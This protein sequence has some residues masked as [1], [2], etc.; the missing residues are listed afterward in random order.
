MNNYS[1]RMR[2]L[3]FLGY[4]GLSALFLP[5]L[6]TPKLVVGIVVDQMRWDFLYRYQDRY[7]AGG[8][9]KLLADGY[10]FEQVLIPYLPTYTACGHASIY[11][12][13]TPAYHGIVGNEWPQEGELRASVWD[14]R[15]GHSPRNLHATTIGDEL[16]WMTNGRARVFAVSMKARASVLPGGHRADGVFWWNK[17]TGTWRT[18]KFYLDTLP[19]WVEKINN[20]RQ[21]D[22]YYRAG[23]Q[24]LYPVDTYKQSTADEQGYENGLVHMEV[25]KFPYHLDSLLLKKDFGAIITTPFANKM[26]ADFAKSLIEE[27]DLGRNKEQVPDMLAISF[28]ATDYIGHSYGPNSLEIEDTYLRLDTVLADFLRFLENRLGRENVLVFLTADHGVSPVP[29]LQRS[30][31]F[32]ARAM[33]NARQRRTL[34]TFLIKSFPRLKGRSPL[35]FWANNQ[36]YLDRVFLAQRNLNYDVVEAKVLEYLNKLPEVLVAFSLHKPFVPAV[37]REIV[38]LMRHSVFLKASGDIQI[39][40]HPFYIPGFW[41]RGKARGTTH[42]AW[43]SYDAHIPLIFYGAGIPQGHSY[44]EHYMTDIAPTVSALLKIPLPSNCIGKPLT[45]IFP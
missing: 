20:K 21:V 36:I 38:E 16:K 35:S 45:E 23:W 29:E 4:W 25:S 3:I 33:H 8:F 42:G 2:L 34:D 7:Q 15:F 31:K 44:E 24:T 6:A 17:K 28:S 41:A 10:S 32:S 1:R 18:S 30:H 12:G 40:F 9:N 39:I 43:N 26:T 5:L 27:Y 37:G 13:S 22:E 11:T 14:K 19:V